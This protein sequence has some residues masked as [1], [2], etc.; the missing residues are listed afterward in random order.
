ME[1]PVLEHRET[2]GARWLREQR[3]RVALWIAVAEGLLVV[4]GVIPAWAALGFAAAGLGFY[5]LAGRNL[6]GTARDVSWIVALAQVCVALVPAL[7]FV[8]GALA[9]MAVAAFAI[10]A[11]VALLADRR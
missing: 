5:L 1:L 11:L 4:L 7:V 9:L 2:R 3:L 8:V 10:V 6:P